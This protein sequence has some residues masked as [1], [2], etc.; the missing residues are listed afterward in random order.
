MKLE[1]TKELEPYAETSCPNIIIALTRLKIR[2]SKHT[3]KAINLSKTTCAVCLSI[4]I[5][6][7]I[8]DKIQNLT[9]KRTTKKPFLITIKNCEIKIINLKKQHF[10]LLCYMTAETNNLAFSVLPL[11]LDW[12]VFSTLR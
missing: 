10:I 11:L 3:N 12:L 7:E 4:S 5:K 1:S 9:V 8:R 2:L 6:V